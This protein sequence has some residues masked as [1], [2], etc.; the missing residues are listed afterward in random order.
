MN[1]K[2]FLSDSYRRQIDHKINKLVINHQI[3]QKHTNRPQTTQTKARCV[4]SIL[5]PLPS[6]PNQKPNNTSKQNSNKKSKQTTSKNS[7][8]ITFEKA[9]EIYK[10][11]C[12]DLNLKPNQTAEKR[13]VEQF[14]NSIFPKSMRFSGLGLG[15]TCIT[16]ICK[17]LLKNPQFVY[18]DL[19]MNRL[20]EEGATIL[21]MYLQL[22]PPIIFLNLK[23]NSIGITGTSSIF[24]SLE[25]NIHLTSLDLGAVD[26]IDRNRLGTPGCK[27]VGNMLLRNQTLSNLNLSMCGVTA[28]GCSYI[29]QAL[30]QNTSLFSLDLTANRFGST[31][32]NALF[33]E[34]GSFGCIETLL[35]SRNAIGNEAS[36]SICRQMI[37]SNSIRSLDLSNNELSKPFLENLYSAFQEGTKISRLSLSKN[38][39]GPECAEYLQLIIRDFPSLTYLDLSLNNLKDEGLIL[40][41][42]GLKQNTTMNSIDLSETGMSDKSGIEFAHV[43]SVHPSLQKLYLAENSLSDESGI[44][45][46]NAL[47]GNITLVVLSLSN[48][49]LRDDSAYALLDTLSVNSTI[50]DLNVDYNDFGP[51]AYVDLSKKI[52]EHKRILNSNVA[53]LAMKKIDWL[54]EEEGRLFQ[55]NEDIK[56]M[57]KEISSALNEFDTKE[58]ELKELCSLKEKEIDEMNE[59]Y[60]EIMK[61]HDNI[62]SIRNDKTREHRHTINL[63]EKQKFEAAAQ[64]KNLSTQRQILMVQRNRKKESLKQLKSDQESEISG[65]LKKKEELQNQ[66]KCAIHE[67]LRKKQEMINQE[68][69]AKQNEKKARLKKKKKGKKTKQKNSAETV[70]SK[71]DDYEM[72][73]T[74]SLKISDSNP[75]SMSTSAITTPSIGSSSLGEKFLNSLQST[76]NFSFQDQSNIFVSQSMSPGKMPKPKNDSETTILPGFRP[77]RPKPEDQRVSGDSDEKPNQE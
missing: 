28:D 71:K 37:L 68:E 44:E 5:S 4:S 31:G 56:D 22:N 69:E 70:N 57:Q 48:N 75:N 59:Q 7:N 27:A 32:A 62:V 21:K 65:L 55:Y 60:E 47:C 16:H 54:K 33:K 64:L 66:I 9:S 14:M 25:K 42:Q 38:K 2:R 76:P 26:G 12:Q 24:K 10:M 34:D 8:P 52:E 6:L 23:S 18:L 67:I 53:D 30:T 13:F 49:E 3:N 17:I 19:S 45:I 39:F 61:K 51:N 43:I 50:S 1:V 58:D 41:A 20:R 36:K 74:S 15:P 46:A 73:P 11:K 29:G 40:I 35:L 77:E 72:P 63:L